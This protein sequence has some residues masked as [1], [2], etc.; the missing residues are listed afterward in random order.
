[1]MAEISHCQEFRRLLIR[2][3]DMQAALGFLSFVPAKAH[4]SGKI[5]DFLYKCLA[6]IPAEW[7]CNSLMLD[8]KP[9]ECHKTAYTAAEFVQ[10]PL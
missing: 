3:F 6:L 8:N 2:C 9:I 10:K 1:M 5:S 7:Y 4:S